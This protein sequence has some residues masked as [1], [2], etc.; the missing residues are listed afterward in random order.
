MSD[1]DRV[2][3]REVLDK[4]DQVLE[5]QGQILARLEPPYTATPVPLTPAPAKFVELTPTPWESTPWRFP[6]A[7]DGK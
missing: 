3:L 4:L 2:L 1:L 5:Q 6:T 7:T